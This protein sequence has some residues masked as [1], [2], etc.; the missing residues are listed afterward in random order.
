[1]RYIDSTIAYKVIP[2]Y[3]LIV[4]FVYEVPVHLTEVLRAVKRESRIND[5]MFAKTMKLLVSSRGY[6]LSD[7]SFPAPAPHL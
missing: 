2:C 6:L 7:F 5:N 1:M 3:P 4:Y